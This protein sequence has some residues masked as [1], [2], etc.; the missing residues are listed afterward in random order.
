MLMQCRHAALFEMVTTEDDKTTSLTS[1][2]EDHDTLEK[3]HSDEPQLPHDVVTD[4]NGDMVSTFCDQ[5]HETMQMNRH[6]Q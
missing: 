6:S 2:Y 4:P 5:F 3:S 1:N